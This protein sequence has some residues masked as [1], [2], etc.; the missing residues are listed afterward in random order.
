MPDQKVE[1][2]KTILVTGS[3]GM[4]GWHFR[5]RLLSMGDQVEVV[6][7]N[8]SQFNDPDYLLK[9]VANA[10]AIVHLA[11]M[12]RG[13][14]AEIVE[15]NIRLAET[16]VAACQRA[17]C[18]PHIVYSSSTHVDG[19]SQYGFSKR[20]AGQ[21]FQSWADATGAKFANLILPHVFGE[22]GKP[23]YNSV[24]ST[25]AHQLA[26]GETP[27]I[28]NDG[29]LELL[30]AQDVAL[31]IWS[32]LEEGQTGEIRPSGMP[33][34]VSELLERLTTLR[35][36]YTDGVIP[37]GKDPM[38]LKLFNT[39]RSY[40][41]VDQ[42]PTDLQLHSDD[43]GNLFE[44]ARADG[45]GQVFLS[46]TRPGITRGEHFHFRKVERFLVVQGDAKIRL[47]RVLTD[48]V[49]TYDVSGDQPQAID[50]P[51]LHTHNITN[52]GDTTLLTLFWSGEHYDP[53]NSDTYYV[54]VEP[55]QAVD[56]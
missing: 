15:T 3:D 50:I 21:R 23:F 42:R 11:G 30:H 52:V 33:M 5:S 39:W 47:R 55:S 48:D 22:H 29:D 14:E 28:A 2:S 32:V 38:A 31:K 4:I 24:V 44:A 56:T 51:T 8:R 1:P 53:E 46:T 41:P 45:Q 10:D 37:D 12:Y 17:N 25:L 34:K 36:R 18:Q 26:V 16:I 40:I 20:T 43:R 35:D 9:A 19:E 6:P 13:E 54:L 7:C 27:E 49:I